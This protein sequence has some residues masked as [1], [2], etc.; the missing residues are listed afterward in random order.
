LYP[1][2]FWLEDLRVQVW[3]LHY[4]VSRH[5]L[6]VFFILLLTW[7]HYNQTICVEYGY[8]LPNPPHHKKKLTLVLCNVLSITS[9]DKVC[10]LVVEVNLSPF[11]FINN[12]QTL[13]HNVAS[14]TPHLY[15]EEFKLTTLVM[16]GI[17][18]ISSLCNVLSITSCDKVCQLVVEVN[19]SPFTFI[20][21]LQQ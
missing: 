12:W 19:L 5:F 4:K 8:P 13:S 16:I 3:N 20:N 14:S 15:W 18:C 9:C 7:L 2:H 1:I 17:D 21:M 11:T 10:Q 6:F